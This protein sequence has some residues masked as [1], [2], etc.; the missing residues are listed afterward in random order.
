VS[1]VRSYL[2]WRGDVTFAERPFNV[3]DN[4]VLCALAYLD[5]AGTVPPPGGGSI[6]AAEAAAVWEEDVREGRR[7]G[8]PRLTVVDP[9]LL[10]DLACSARFAD[11]RLSDHVDD[12]DLVAGRQFSAMSVHLSDGST[13]VAFRGTDNTLLGWKEDFTASFEVVPAQL[14][15]RDYLVAQLARVAGPVRV[16]GH[17]KGGNL[18]LFA[19]MSVPPAQQ[20][21]LVAVHNNDGPGL[22]PDIVDEAGIARIEGRVVSVVPE[23]SVIGM[24]FARGAPTH[25]V[26]S[27]VRGL[28]Q[29]DL[30]TWEVEGTTLC[31]RPGPSPRA[32]MLN[33]A[34]GS[35]LEVAG[36]DERRAF[37]E[38]FFGALSAGGATLI[39]EVSRSEHG[40]FESVLFALARSRGTTKRSRGLARQAGVRVLRS[41]DYASM[42]RGRAS[43]RA[44]STLALGVYFLVVPQLAT[45]VLG[46]L[47]MFLALVVVAIRAGR[48]Y[49]RFRRMHRVSWLY[50]G[51]LLLGFVAAVLFLVHI[52]YL[53]APT[54]VVLG[55]ALLGNAWFTGRYAQQLQRASVPRKARVALL[56]VSAAASLGL[57]LVA[58]STGGQVV[59]E[60]VT[61]AGQ[62]CVVAGMLELFFTIRDELAYRYSVEVAA[63]RLAEVTRRGSWERPVPRR[64]G[65][66]R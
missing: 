34:I 24:L 28:L 10:M 22:S 58:L 25:T 18:A 7:A 31:A 13:Y 39:A 12:L 4:L 3:I 14:A 66:R 19:S 21:R 15:A 43:V 44:G 20:E 37:T 49:V 35:W 38:A 56:A 61:V 16:G 65:E 47:T 46:A 52:D 9:G 5:L 32:Q 54:N 59:P 53:V 1:D 11:A 6:S 57:G 40:S 30:L 8:S 60:F 23:F 42:L 36:H 27:S 64:H 2:R 48:Y 51:V 55:A 62:Y 17:S 45:Q 29:H 63:D 26:A 41:V 50:P 33:H